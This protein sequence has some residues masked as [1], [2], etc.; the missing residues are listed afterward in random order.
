LIETNH[1]P[2]LCRQI[3]VLALGRQNI[4]AAGKSSNRQSFERAAKNKTGQ[5]AYARADANIFGN[6]STASSGLDLTF[7]VRS[8]G[9][10]AVRAVDRDQSGYERNCLPIGQGDVTEPQV[11]FASS[12]QYCYSLA[13]FGFRDFPFNARACGN[14]DRSTCS[15]NRLSDRRSESIAWL[16]SLG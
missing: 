4:S 6:V 3:N 13:R 1:H 5:G 16:R 8:P 14:Q 12:A 15:A 10:L 11:E 9:V 7:L 2:G